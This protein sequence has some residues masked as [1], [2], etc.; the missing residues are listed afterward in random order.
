MEALLKSLPEILKQAASTRLGILALMIIVLAIL[1]Y[2]FFPGADVKIYLDAAA[3]E[4]AR[5]RANDPAHSGGPAAVADVATALTA[6]DELDRTRKASPLVVADDAVRVDTTEKS[7]EQV[8]DE[9]LRVI[10]ARLDY[11]RSL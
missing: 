6:R 4:R 3:E 2:I 7:V 8:V 1:A 11:L 5:R 9:V 10:R